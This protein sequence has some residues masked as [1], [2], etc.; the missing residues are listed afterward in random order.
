MAGGTWTTQNKVRPGLYVNVESVPAAVGTL[1]E[2]GTTT[3][4]LPLSWGPTKQI[5]TIQS[6]EDIQTVLGYDMTDEKM[7]LIREALKRAATLL[8]YRLNTGTHASV[9][10]G[11]AGSGEEGETQTG[12]TLTAQAKYPGVRGNDLAVAIQSNVDQ[13]AQFDVKV[14]LA[15]REVEA[16]T[17][18]TAADVN[19]AWVELAGE[20]QTSAGLTLSGGEDGEVTNEDHTDYLTAIQVESFQTVSLS[21][22]EQSLKELYAAFVNR[23]REDEGVKIQAVLENDTLPDSEGV[24]SVQNGVILADGTVLSAAEATAWVAGATAAATVNQSLTYS[25]YDGAVDVNPRLTNTEIESALRDGAFLFT[26]SDGRAIV[27]QDINTF[28]SYT[29]TKRQHFSKNRVVRVLDGISN[30]VKRIFESFYIGQ[31]DNNDD[32]RNMFRQEIVN[33]LSA[34]QGMNAI[35]NVDSQTDVA[36]VAGQD[37]DIFIKDVIIL[38]DILTFATLL[39]PII[40]ALVEVTKRTVAYPKNF[41]P[42]VALLLGIIVGLLAAPFSDL[43]VAFRLWAGALAGLAAT[44][45]F[46]ISNPR[47][48]TTKR[49][50]Q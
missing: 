50:E 17:V 15:G 28:T 10:V 1:G 45:L 27:E 6:G 26:H 32:G 33:H 7:L 14:F 24:I 46:E 37:S 34:L 19:S 41:V 38:N 12:T 39:V 18:A 22:T 11:E 44:G 42:L 35:Q 9:T 36:V 48:G 8:L 25:A 21:S 40:A 30:D 49:L 29:P 16:H 3:L 4:A 13:P 47:P 20:L 2:R 23:L 31:V 43:V 5:I